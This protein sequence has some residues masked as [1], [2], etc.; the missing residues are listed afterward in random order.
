MDPD[1]HEV[2]LVQ[3]W[4]PSPAP[5]PSGTAPPARHGERAGRL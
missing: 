3:Y 5:S 2:E 1:G 4:R